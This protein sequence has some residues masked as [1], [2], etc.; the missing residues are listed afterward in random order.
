[1]LHTEPIVGTARNGIESR[2]PMAV[3]DGDGV[4][5]CGGSGGS[6]RR[7][8][9]TFAGAAAL[10]VTL[11][12]GICRPAFTDTVSPVTAIIHA[13]PSEL[14]QHAPLCS[15]CLLL[16]GRPYHH[17]LT[18]IYKFAS[19]QSVLITP[20]SPAFD[21]NER[22]R[23]VFPLDDCPGTITP[24]STDHHGLQRRWHDP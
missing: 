2:A 15:W 14:Q 5:V 17:A 7:G 12:V 23:I 9:M 10:P 22:S 19:E 6:L 16:S 11:D 13:V 21:T 4:G 1:M 8:R 24:P 3:A 20:S 18:R